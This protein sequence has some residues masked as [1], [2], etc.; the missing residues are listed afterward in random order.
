MNSNNLRVILEM[1]DWKQ[2]FTNGTKGMPKTDPMI[3][4]YVESLLK[5]SF[6][7]NEEKVNNNPIAPWLVK[8]I[9]EIGPM[10]VNTEKLNRIKSVIEYVKKT[11]NVANIPKMDLVQ[12]SDFAKEKLDKMAEKEKQQP[13]N[14]PAKTPD[15]QDSTKKK[16]LTPQEK[17]ILYQEK[18]KELFPELKDESDGN[19]ERVWTCTDGSGRMWVKVLNNSWLSRSCSDGSSWGIV[20][21]GG[22]FGNS[23]YVNY[24]LIGPPKGKASPIYTI[25]GMGVLKSKSSIAEVKQEGN[26]QPGSQITRGWSD[27]DEMLIEFLSFA[28]EA[29]WIQYFGDYSGNIILNPSQSL[30]GGGIGFLY[31]LAQ[32]RPELFKVLA[33]NRPDMIAQNQ[34]IIDKLFPNAEELLNF[35]IAE[36]AKENPEQFLIR[37]SK[38]IERYGKEA[39]D[40]L[41]KIDLNFYTKTK[42]VLIESILSDLVEVLDNSKV[43]PIIKELDLS[44]FIWN[45]KLKFYKLIN[46]LSIKNNKNT[47]TFLLTKYIKFIVGDSKE[48]I[49]GTI[50]F[51][52]E[53][54]KP[55]LEVHANAVKDPEDGKYYGIRE[56][57]VKDENGNDEI[58]QNGNKIKKQIRFEIPDNLLILS[59]KERRDFIKK[60]EE[61]LKQSINSDEKGKEITF[62]RLLFSQS[63][64]QEVEKTMTKE[65]E[66]FVSYYDNKFKA[67]EKKKAQTP[68]GIVESPYMPGEFEL[69]SILNPKGA[70]TN[71]NK[72]YYPIGIEN[73]RK[74]A[75]NIIKYYYD[76][77]LTSEKEKIKKIYGNKLTPEIGKQEL[78]A[79]TPKLKY[80]AIKDYVLTL[81]YSGE[82]EEDAL[83]FFLNNF[84]PE[85]IGFVNKLDGYNIMLSNVN[86][87]VSEDLFLS[88]LQ[89]F[90]P[91]LFEF[92]EKGKLIY[93]K[94]L[95]DISR[96][97]FIVKSGTFVR[98]KGSNQDLDYYERNWNLNLDKPVIYNGPIFLVPN[99][100]YKVLKV[101]DFAGS[102]NGKILVLDEGYTSV[103]NEVIPRTQRWF[104]SKLFNIK[105]VDI[106]PT[107]NEDFFRTFVQNRIRIMAENKKSISYTGIILDNKSQSKL[108]GWV[109]EMIKSKKLPNMSEWEWSAD[110]ATIK[111]GRMDDVSLLNQYVELKVLQYAFDDKISAVSIVPIVNGEEIEFTKD[112][113]HITIAFDKI[114]GARPVQ[115]NELTNW[116]PVPKSFI[117]KG[118]IKEVPL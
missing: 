83:S 106:L 35:N 59:Q 2:H 78:A 76:S 20:C 63:N 113:P 73:A 66:E 41:N 26:V 74:S 29:K 101:G 28:P 109:K 72:I 8:I 117:L 14:N 11:G 75:S 4:G 85:K 90:K 102:K 108:S 103:T 88:T 39:I 22:S 99:K 67:G 112:K 18:S 100:E 44:N 64:S 17:A 68:T 86:S 58:D 79:R 43:E 30:Y 57:Y 21:Q 47:I 98:F 93:E 56:E 3:L 89:K 77:D 42:P 62:L 87:M 84:P 49:K 96:Q 52:R 27:A 69:F 24:Q 94:Y 37:L 10:N 61:Y 1:K 104:S 46:S 9:G 45:N 34:E 105:S 13:D 55:K 12:G 110:H 81:I 82:K 50:S 48:A 60:N 71:K 38:Y 36:F 6:D 97:E 80:E 23:K 7:G 91:T 16:K 32:Q 53:M 116:R 5:K 19:I 31:H 70:I 54:E 114:N 25:V 15:D 118:I 51:L 33:N 115:S 65:K 95:K 40:E 111:T 107:V 92:G